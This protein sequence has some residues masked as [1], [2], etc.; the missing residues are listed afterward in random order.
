[1]AAVMN[2]FVVRVLQDKRVA[3]AVPTHAAK[4]NVRR[5]LVKPRRLSVAVSPMVAGIP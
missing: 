5:S 3:R 2:L 1:M 4:V